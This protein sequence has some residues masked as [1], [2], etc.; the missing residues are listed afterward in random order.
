M[1]AWVG[2]KYWGPE[3]GRDHLEPFFEISDCAAKVRLH[4]TI[5]C[6]EDAHRFIAKLRLLS[7][8][9]T[10]A[11]DALERELNEGRAFK[12]KE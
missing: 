6:D 5:E 4:D 3:E 7:E 9:A 1:F 11:A 2:M 10:E 8:I 12:E